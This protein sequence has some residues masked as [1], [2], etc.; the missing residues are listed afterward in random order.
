MEYFIIP[1]EGMKQ[2]LIA[3]VTSDLVFIAAPLFS[4][5]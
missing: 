5:T 1:L 2:N 4:P 3:G